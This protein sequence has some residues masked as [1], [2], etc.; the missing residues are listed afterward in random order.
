MNRHWTALL[1]AAAVILMIRIAQAAE[2]LS[3]AAEWLPQE[4]VVSFEV[5]RPQA[6]LDLAL[7]PR[8][9][10]AIT[11]LP[12]Y[13]KQASTPGYRQFVQVI[14]FLESSLG[15][16]W[17]TA[18]RK[19]TGGGMTLAIE[20]DGTVLL[21]VDAVDEKMLRDLR[22]TIVTFAQADAAKQQ[23]AD[24]IESAEYRGVT[25]WQ[26]GK[27]Q[28]HFIQGGR[29]VFSNRPAA[30]KEVIDR[31]QDP[32]PSR[33]AQLPAY[34][35]AR[36]AAGSGAAVVGFVNL[37]SIKGHP[38]IR[39]ALD[40]KQNPLIALLLARAI[41]AARSRPGWQFGLGVDDNTLGHRCA[42]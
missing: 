21:I 23:A 29:L 8:A 30:L 14:K 1:T 18:V 13:Q 19:L 10:R 28:A 31:S 4:T 12:V 39:A 6:L 34:R 3:P 26:A 38:P 20:P 15:A 40:A 17:K 16:D 32:A 5:T 37:A 24:R 35:Q 33:L 9:I 36:Q 27:E 2:P 41:E 11:A 22:E 42:C 7:S 25:V